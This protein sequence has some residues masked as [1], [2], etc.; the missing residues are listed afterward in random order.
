ML[1][2]VKV[3]LTLKEKNAKIKWV[4][5]SGWWYLREHA[6][7]EIMIDNHV[8]SWLD[9][10]TISSWMITVPPDANLAQPVI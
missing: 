1:T 9:N 3:Y 7:I 5:T 8:L 4:L 2:Y 10:S 6:L